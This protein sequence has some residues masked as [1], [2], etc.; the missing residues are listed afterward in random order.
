MVFDHES[1]STLLAEELRRR[2]RDNPRYSLRS[3]ARSLKISPGALSEILRGRRDF[4]VRAIA[5]VAK[6]IG[7]NAAEAQHVLRIAKRAK[8]SEIEDTI[9]TRPVDQRILDEQ[10]FN[11]V[12]EWYH[13]AILNLLEC[14]D[15]AWKDIWISARLGI[16]RT[17]A[18]MAMDLLLRLKLVVRKKEKYLSASDHVL[19][20]SEIPSSAVRAYHREILTKA[21]AALEAQSLAERD[22]SGIGMA[23]NPADIPAVK[24]EIAEFQDR[25]LAKF[26]GGKK[27]EVYFTEIAFFKLTV[28]EQK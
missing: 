1:I 11:L 4:P 21:I 6:T 18:K 13:F 10:I 28:G 20:H 19:T 14:D 2:L 9:P 25:L 3:F 15:F 16:S 5:N 26:T 27:S 8:L 12:S 7:M 24:K 22:I 23:I 17:Q